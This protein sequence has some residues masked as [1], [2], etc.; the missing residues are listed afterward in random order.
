[1]YYIVTINAQILDPDV[2][3]DEY[4]V[5]IEKGE[6]SLTGRPGEYQ[7]AVNG[8]CK[9]KNAKEW[10]DQNHSI[11]MLNYRVGEDV[12]PYDTVAAH[13]IGQEIISVRYGYRKKELS[14]KLTPENYS[15]Y[16]R[17]IRV[18]EKNDFYIKGWKI[19]SEWKRSN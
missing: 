1:M 16:E 12:F 10:L 2:M 5:D 15:I 8:T 7:N 11:R 17:A 19:F 4:N 13:K 3:K 9:R 14:L 18:Y 6:Y